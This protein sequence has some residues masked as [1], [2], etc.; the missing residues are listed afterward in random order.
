MVS[1][2]K[3]GGWKSLFGAYAAFILLFTAASICAADDDYKIGDGDGLKISVWGVNELSV[4]AKVRPD[5]KITLPGIGDVIA[6][7]FTPMDLSS[8]LAEK[9]QN[10][11]QKPIVTVTVAD[12]KNSKVYLFFGQGVTTGGQ[13]PS[14]SG[15]LE[16]TKG[17][18]SGAHDLPRRTTLLKFLSNFGS[19]KGADLAKAYLMRGGKKLDINFYDLFVKFDLSKDIMLKPE[20]II[21]IPDN[22]LS[23]IYIMGA[24]NTPKY[25][26]YTE[27]LRVLDLIMEAGGFNKFAKENN[28]VLLRKNTDGS[29]KEIT[30]KGKDLMRDGDLSQNIELRPGDYVIVKEGIF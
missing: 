13:E 18:S 17:V 23:K 14:Q 24:V 28:V 15:N 30:V 20:D 8:K 21:Y 26:S 2:L 27:G 25:V 12:I 16:I 6:S 3:S 7:G 5:G 10:F 11:V 1:H 29:M 19:L 22:Q 9:L 4:D